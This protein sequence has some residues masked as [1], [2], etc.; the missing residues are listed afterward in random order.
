MFPESTIT[1]LSDQQQ[2]ITLDTV[3]NQKRMVH[4]WRFFRH[5]FTFF[6]Q[7]SSFQ[8]DIFGPWGMG[9][10]CD[11][12]LRTPPA[13][14][15]AW[16]TWNVF[17]EVTRSFLEIASAPSHLSDDCMNSIERFVVLMYD[18]GSQLSPVDEARQQLFCQR[19]RK[20]DLQI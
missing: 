5:K 20:P 7:T 13:Y 12:T 8:A 17:P 11:R 6:S 15:P 3:T 18:R 14:A 10:G 4:L 1:V 9:G 2:K 19:S 16:D